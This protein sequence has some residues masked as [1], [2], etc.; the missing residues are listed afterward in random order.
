MNEKPATV[1][2]LL[3][4]PEAARLARVSVPTI[5]RRISAGEI[6]ALRIGDFSG[7]IRIPEN[8]FKGWLYG[9]PRSAA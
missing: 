8:E 7:P 2:R 9:D 6:P 5:Y 4:V 3:T 1:D